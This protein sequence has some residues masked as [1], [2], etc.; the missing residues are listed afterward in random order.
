[1][2]FLLFCF[3]CLACLALQSTISLGKKYKMLH[4]LS[5]LWMVYLLLFLELVLENNLWSWTE[6]RLWTNKSSVSFLLYH[7]YC[8][9]VSFFLLHS[10]YLVLY[11]EYT[12]WNTDCVTSSNWSVDGEEF[13][14][15]ISKVNLRKT[16]MTRIMMIFFLNKWF[17]WNAWSNKQ[18]YDLR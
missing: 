10:T 9:Q 16:R 4:S 12:T 11:P 18:R 8:Y 7:F 13:S 6:A 3:H 5:E 1:M 14:M 17:Y 15:Y 2:F